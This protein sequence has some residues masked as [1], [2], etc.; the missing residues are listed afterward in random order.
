MSLSTQATTQTRT[1][2]EQHILYENAIRGNFV[3]LL[4]L[5]TRK[6]QE[7]EQ[8]TEVSFTKRLVKWVESFFERGD[9]DG[10]KDQECSSKEARD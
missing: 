6:N 4:D 8:P 2:I 7:E 9:L 10:D 5:T 3:K 1:E